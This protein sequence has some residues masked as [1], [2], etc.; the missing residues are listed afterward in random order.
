ME[1]NLEKQ[2][3]D[4]KKAIFFAGTRFLPPLGF[5][6]KERRISPMQT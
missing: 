2:K 1:F 6:L 3:R 5:L 4:G